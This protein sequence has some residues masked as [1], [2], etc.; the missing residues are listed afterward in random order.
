MSDV[1]YPIVRNGLLKSGF[2][3]LAVV[4][5]AVTMSVVGCEDLTGTKPVDTTKPTQGKPSFGSGTVRDQQYVAGVPIPIL[6]L[7]QASGGDGTLAY[8][9]YPEV[10][11]LTF[12]AETRTLSGVPSSAG[13]YSV[14]YEV[15]DTDGDI[16]TLSFRIVAEPL[17]ML[18]WGNVPGPLLIERASLDGRNREVLLGN[19]SSLLSVEVAQELIYWTECESGLAYECKI[20]RANRDGRN[21]VDLITGLGIGAIDVAI[22]TARGKIY[23]T[24]FVPRSTRADPAGWAKL[25]Q[26]DLDGTAVRDL[27]VTPGVRIASIALDVTD[28]MMYWTEHHI[29]GRGGISHVKIRRADLDGVHTEDFLTIAWNHP[30]VPGVYSELSNELA[31]AGGKIYFVSGRHN[32]TVIERANLDGTGSEIVTNRPATTLALDVAN[33]KIYWTEY[34]GKILRANLDGTGTEE[35][36]IASDTSR[37]GLTVDVADR[38]VLWIERTEKELAE[39]GQVTSTIRRANPDGSALQDLVVATFVDIPYVNARE[40][41]VDVLDRRMYWAD[42]HQ[43]IDGPHTFMIQRADLD[44]SGFQV[45]HSSPWP[46]G[47]ELGGMAFDFVGRKLYWVEAVEGTAGWTNTIKRANLDGTSP[48]DLLTVEQDVWAIAVDP[49]GGRAYWRDENAIRSANLDGTDQRDLVVTAP[50][51]GTHAVDSIAHKLY[52]RERDTILSVNLDGTGK[53]DLA[54]EANGAELAIDSA[55]QRLYWSHNPTEYSSGTT[56]IR[57]ANLDGTGQTTAAIWEGVYL[58]AMALGIR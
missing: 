2:P 58:T 38:K 29:G 31:I 40:I 10:P 20:R 35:Y 1:H 47:H 50:S 48:Q 30:V 24:E 3:A 4:V 9:L 7:P 14:H 33:G 41:A 57:S 45:V 6:T 54:L 26:A 52:W 19:S 5:A 43:P 42:L 27:V 46:L 23:W 18:Y 22:D 12:S 13:T 34:D 21:A 15:K 11:G 55:G 44:G 51:W 25:R 36:M 53:R 49:V 39:G 8:R 32:E 56:V 37:W 16:A 28:G 17:T